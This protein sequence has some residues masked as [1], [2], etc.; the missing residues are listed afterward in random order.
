LPAENIGQEILKPA[1]DF[2][3]RYMPAKNEE[4]FASALCGASLVGETDKAVS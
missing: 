2:L 3:S 1:V 4:V